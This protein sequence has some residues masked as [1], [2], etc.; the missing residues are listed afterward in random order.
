[1]K[2]IRRC[3]KDDMPMFVQWQRDLL[4]TCPP[5]ETEPVSMS[6]WKPNRK[7]AVQVA[8]EARSG[9]IPVQCRL[10]IV[11]ALDILRASCRPDLMRWCQPDCL[12]IE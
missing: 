4:L 7:G 3:N 5:Q 10:R 1:M 6:D 8:G 11:R 12:K 9:I 2:G